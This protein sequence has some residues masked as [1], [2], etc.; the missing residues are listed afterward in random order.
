MALARATR[1]GPRARVC[2]RRLRRATCPDLALF[3]PRD[4]DV[5]VEARIDDARRAEAAARERRPAHR[6][7]RGLAGRLRA[8]RAS[9]YG[10]SRG[11]LGEY[12]A[13]SHSLFSRA[14]RP[15]RRRACSATTG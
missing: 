13:A 4:R 6:Q 11:F 1:R 8:S 2:P 7:L 14:G 5:A 10:N 9:L 15:G 3:D 12:D